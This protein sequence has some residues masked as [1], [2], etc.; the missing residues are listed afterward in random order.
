M[1]VRENGG[2]RENGDS[3]QLNTPSGWVR[4]WAGLVER[5][6][7]LDVACGT[8][9]HAFLFAERG[10][11]VFAVDRDE[12]LLPAPVH[13]VKADLEDG[14]PWP[15]R[16]RKFAAVVV[17]NYL[18]RPLFARLAESLEEGGVLIYETF[19]LGNERSA[20]WPDVPSM[21]DLGFPFS[22]DSPFGIAGPK[23]MDPA[24]VQK[25]HDAFKKSLDDPKVQELMA[26][27]LMPPRYADA[28]GYLE[29]VKKV[30][31]VEAEGLKRIGM[32]RD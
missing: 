23:G 27:N 21:K 16:G 5:G 25:L 4:R 14:S 32:G 17:T 11:E 22:F 12:Q 28:K 2:S 3:H 15:F 20:K 18:Y 13:F 10:L 8:G 24:V 30:S 31:A 7:V 19:M 6:P 9:R 26:R 29:I 1:P